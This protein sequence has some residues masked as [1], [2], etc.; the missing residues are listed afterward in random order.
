MEAI[1]K[2][3]VSPLLLLSCISLTVLLGLDC[4]PRWEKQ[5]KA[6]SLTLSCARSG[7]QGG[8]QVSS[9]PASPMHVFNPS[10]NLI[11]SFMKFF[12]NV[13]RYILVVG[14]CW[15]L[16]S[17]YRLAKLLE[18]GPP[19]KTSCW[20]LSR[21][22]SFLC[23]HWISALVSARYTRIHFLPETLGHTGKC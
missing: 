20:W 2:G 18:L 17:S 22:N 7:P 12:T 8:K 19:I 14:T 13:G 9:F 15:I 11:I 6:A 21:G 4:F 5:L 16:Q 10:L 23:L 1:E 3:S